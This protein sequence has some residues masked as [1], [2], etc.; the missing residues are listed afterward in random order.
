MKTKDWFVFVAVMTCSL[1]FVVGVNAGDV[2]IK[3]EQLRLG[4]SA[5]CYWQEGLE[6]IDESNYYYGTVV[7]YYPPPSL[8]YC[9]WPTDYSYFYSSDL[10]MSWSFANMAMGSKVE[11]VWHAPSG[12]IYSGGIV[13]SSRDGD[14]CWWSWWPSGPPNIEGWW[15]VDFTVNGEVW[16]TDSFYVYACAYLNITIDPVEG[17]KVVGSGIDCGED[18]SEEFWNDEEVSLTAYPNPGWKFLHWDDGSLCY[19]TNPLVVTM[20]QSRYLT[21]KFAPASDNVLLTAVDQTSLGKRIPLI[22]IHGNNSENERDFRWGNFLKKFRKDAEFSEKYKV[23]K[24]RWDSEKSNLDNGIALGYAIDS[25]IALVNK[26]VTIL[27]HSRGGLVARYFMN[28]YTIKSGRYAGKLGGERVKYLVTLATPHRGSPGADN[29]W[30]VYSLDYG[31]KE[32]VAKYLCEVYLNYV[33]DKKTHSFLVWDDW[34]NELTDGQFCWYS[35]L[36]EKRICSTMRTNPD[37]LELNET[38]KYLSKII[39]YGGNNYK[40]DWVVPMDAKIPE[41]IAPQVFEHSQLDAASILLARMPILPSGYLSEDDIDDSYRPFQANDGM[42]PL[43]SALFLKPGAGRLFTVDKSGRVIYDRGEVAGYAQVRQG[44]ILGNGQVDHLD[45]L[46]D[47]DILEKVIL[48]M[49]S[50]H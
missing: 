24:F 41:A 25:S 21:A 17:G 39:A 20:D 15:L 45:F 10:V 29:R 6:S 18:C 33:W 22:L 35:N 12:E 4:S 47:S 34:D 46:D 8:Y 44:I 2:R 13:D 27:A 23:Y 11:I 40:K 37:L 31:F 16:Y 48:K 43:I 9:Y 19:I 42:V 50:L 38:E 32:K 28:R 49:K 14:Q 3:S 7:G 5:G 1:C 36:Y 30:V 26:K